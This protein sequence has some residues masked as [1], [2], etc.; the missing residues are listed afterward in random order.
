[1]GIGKRALLGL[2]LIVG[3]ALTS[4]ARNQEPIVKIT[5]PTDGADLAGQEVQFQAEASD[6]DGRIEKYEWSFG[7]GKRGT[8]QNPKHTYQQGGNYTVTLVVTDD[9]KATSRASIKIHINHEPE[10]VATAKI[11]GYEGPL[12]AVSGDAPLEVAFDGSKSKDRDGTLASFYWDFGDGSTSSEISPAHTYAQTGSYQVSLTVIDDKGAKASDSVLVDVYPPPITAQK[13]LGISPPKY[14]LHS[15]HTAGTD[16]Q[17]KKMIYYYIVGGD[18]RVRELEAKAIFVDVLLQNSRRRDIEQI[19]VYLFDEEKSNFMKSG[20]YEHYVGMAVWERGQDILKDT[21][22]NFNKKYFS[23]RGLRVY[24]YTLSQ[25]QITD[26]KICPI[27]KDKRIQRVD[28]F[29]E[30]KA[31]CRQ[32]V[33]NTLKDI[34]RWV[35]NTDDGYLINIKLQESNKLL[36]GALKAKS[37]DV[38]KT[39]PVDLLEY[40]PKGWAVNEKT[41]KISLDRLTC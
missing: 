12:K 3:L 36:G 13:L 35:L 25:Q 19:T 17:S 7:D 18:K 26:E 21:A 30:E 32:V 10:A 39:L 37:V 34:S 40:K 28:I 41:L 27:C 31:P 15:Q 6:P 8:E 20:D 16:P 11:A 9:K 29:I 5:S 14:R 4:C 2:L 24:G 23:G 22:F 1:M 33:I 38:L